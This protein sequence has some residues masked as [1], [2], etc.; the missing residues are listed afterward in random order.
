MVEDFDHEKEKEFVYEVGDRFKGNGGDERENLEWLAE[1]KGIGE[2]DTDYVTKEEALKGSNLLRYVNTLYDD[3]DVTEKLVN[4]EIRDE[5]KGVY[6]AEENERKFLRKLSETEKRDK[7]HFDRKGIKTEEE[8]Y[9][10]HPEEVINDRK[11]EPS[12]IKGLYEDL[13]EVF[14]G[15]KH[16]LNDRN[17]LPE[18]GEIKGGHSDAV[19]NER[20]LLKDL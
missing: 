3:P 15:H 8:V 14:K 5:A 19:L 11:K 13:D 18:E 7:A 10:N 6:R 4:K 17:L 9:E 12:V 20:E 2:E 1:E 16:A